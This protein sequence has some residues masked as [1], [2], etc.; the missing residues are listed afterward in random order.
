MPTP[1]LLQ[2][3]SVIA[4]S[5]TGSGKTA[6]FALPIL[7]K[8]AANPYGVFA[9]VLT[10]TRCVLT[11][12]LHV[13]EVLHTQPHS[14]MVLLRELAM[15]LAEQFRAFGAGMG[16][17]VLPKRPCL[18]AVIWATHP[19]LVC[20]QEAVVVGGLDMQT[21]L[22]ALAARPHVVVATPGRLQASTP[23]ACPRLAS[24]CLTH[25]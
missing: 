4:T 24:L 10:P 20:L 7:Q 9:L 2:G 1:T 16:L 13:T 11:G 22:R 15:Q 18:Q 14:T 23:A 3:R 8:L 12:S 19:D 21:Q 5:H 17:K 6:T 25:A